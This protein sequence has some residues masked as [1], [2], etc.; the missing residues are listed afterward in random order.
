MSKT[1]GNSGGNEFD[2]LRKG[3]DEDEIYEAVAV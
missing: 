1:Y 3:D 2:P